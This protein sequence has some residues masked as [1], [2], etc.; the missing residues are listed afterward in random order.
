[1]KKQKGEMMISVMVVMMVVAWAWS[2]HL[3]M[4]HMGMGHASHQSSEAS[5]GH[6]Q[7]EKTVTDAKPAEVSEQY[8][9][10]K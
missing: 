9:H 5:Q 7:N 3:G 6:Q 1:M 8:E 2:D 4:G 10:G